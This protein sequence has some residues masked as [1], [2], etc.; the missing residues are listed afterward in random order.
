VN[1]GGRDGNCG[2]FDE[3]CDWLGTD[4]TVRTNPCTADSDS[5]PSGCRGWTSDCGAS[6]VVAI[7]KAAASCAEVASEPAASSPVP[8]S[9]MRHCEIFDGAFSTGTRSKNVILNC[10]F[11]YFCFPLNDYAT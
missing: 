3:D 7:P 8:L 2:Y 4:R 10:L 9:R 5:E 6:A 1:Y 11:A